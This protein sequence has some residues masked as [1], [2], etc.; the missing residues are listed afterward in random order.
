VNRP[1]QALL[2]HETLG[3]APRTGGPPRRFWDRLLE[4]EV[5]LAVTWRQVR[6]HRPKTDASDD[7]SALFIGSC[8]V[9]RRDRVILAQVLREE[10]DGEVELAAP[11][12]V[13][14]P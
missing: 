13:L 14:A 6:G 10:G 2:N 12:R 11:A 3:P 8:V 1:R 5:R 4:L 9:E 7:E